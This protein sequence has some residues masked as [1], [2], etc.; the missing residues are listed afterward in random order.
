MN[1]KRDN[2]SYPYRHTPARISKRRRPWAPPSSEN[3]EIID[4]PTSKPP[5]PP[6]LVVLGLPANCSVLELKS[7]FEIYGSLSRIRIDKDGVGTVSYRSA[8]SA[9]AAIAGSLEPSFGISIDS[10]KLQVVWETDPLVKWR[11]GVTVGDGKDKT[12]PSL[13]SK[14]LRPEMPLRK[15][16][17]RNRLASAIVNPRSSNLDGES[18]GNLSPVART[19]FK[20]REILAYDDIL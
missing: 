20:H 15:H 14:L 9:E 19:E 4:K 13:S 2:S 11:E 17:R 12:S 18:G 6:V 16:G 3:D 7:R 1:R 10:K 5:P 8:E